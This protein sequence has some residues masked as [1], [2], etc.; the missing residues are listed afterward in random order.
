MD[1]QRGH[2]INNDDEHRMATDLAGASLT[3]PRENRHRARTS[4]LPSRCS[5]RRTISLDPDLALH[6]LTPASPPRHTH[7]TASS[8]IASSG[9][10]DN[11]D[12]NE[13]T[14]LG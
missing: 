6:F 12:A 1:P 2:A 10:V 13:H 14:A 8:R 11:Q 5:L 9:E 4:S 3:S 7:E